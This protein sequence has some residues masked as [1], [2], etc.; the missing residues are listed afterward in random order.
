MIKRF[1]AILALVL[2]LSPLAQAQLAIPADFLR[3]IQDQTRGF[4]AGAAPVLPQAVPDAGGRALFPFQELKGTLTEEELEMLHGVSDFIAKNHIEEVEAKKLYYAAMKG[5]LSSL[6]KHSQFF[7]P[8]EFKAFMAEM[9]G[10]GFVGVGAGLMKKEDGKG[11]GIAYTMPNSPAAK[12]GLKTGDV[13]LEVDGV[14]TLD[15]KTDAIVEKIRGKDGT[16]VTLKIEST[17]PATKL[18][19]Q[20]AVTMVRAAIAQPYVLA[21]TIKPGVG[22]LYF[23][24]F[25]SKGDAAVL[26]AVRQ[27]VKKDGVTSLVIDV[28]FNPGGDL[29]TVRKISEAFLSKGDTLYQLKRRGA[30]MVPVKSS[31]D[32]EFK[33]LALKILINSGSASAS[34]ILAGALKDNKRATVYGSASYGKGSAQALIPL[35]DGSGMKLTVQKWYTPNGSSIEKNAAGA[36]GVSPDVAVAVTEEAEGKAF[37]RIINEL[38]QAPLGDPAPDATLDKALE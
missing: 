13:I 11:Q 1:A 15:M 5:M 27:L 24:S 18:K 3:R 6:D 14:S 35:Q 21:K 25:R 4:G 33:S 7:D 16:K 38:H 12:A 17:D 10:D 32:G 9:S 23:G 31:V 37:A 36:G 28:R 26:D 2:G 29:E 22:Y 34:E 30:A 20:R 19:T 8:K